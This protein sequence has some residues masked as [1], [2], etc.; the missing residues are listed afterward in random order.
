[1]FQNTGRH[2]LFTVELLRAMQERG[3]LIRN[4]GGDWVQAPAL[5][6]ERL[7]GR[8]EGV[9]EER[10]GRLDGDLREILSVASVEGETFT[11]QV[12]AHVA[13]V[14]ERRLLRALSHE[15]DTRHHLVQEIGAAQIAETDPF[16]SHYRFSHVLFQRYLYNVLSS[17]ERRLLHGEAGATGKAVKYRLQ[18]GDQARM[19]YAHEEAIGHYRRALA[20]QKE[21]GDDDQAARTLMKLGVTHH[22]A[23]QF[24]PARQAFSEAFELHKRA[25]PLLPIAPMPSARHPL[26]LPWLERLTL[27]PALAFDIRSDGVVDQLFSG[28]VELSPELDIVPDLAHSW[29]VSDGA[30]RFVFHLRDDVRWSDGTPLTAGDVEYAWKRVLNPATGSPSA[31]ML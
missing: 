7:P 25:S 9:I 4:E 21:M 27:D 30:R 8:V 19:A 28:L 31:G 10:I 26:R 6:W 22:S 29:E 13:D 17:G 12:V 2:P 1:M 24:Q 15:L 23:F 5:D 3:D 18:A 16:V 11:A 14:P 20:L